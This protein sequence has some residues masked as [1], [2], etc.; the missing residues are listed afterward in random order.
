MQKVVKAKVAEWMTPISL[1][2]PECGHQAQN[3]GSLAEHAMKEHNRR[4]GEDDQRGEEDDRTKL[5]CGICDFV[6][7][8]VLFSPT[9]NRFAM[10]FV[11]DLQ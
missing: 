7:R 9:L 11:L 10:L 1:T 3:A 5:E 4:R 2:C 6:T 8:M